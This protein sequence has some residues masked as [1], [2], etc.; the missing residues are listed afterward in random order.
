ME[1]RPLRPDAEILNAE[2]QP[3]R[4]WRGAAIA[5]ALSIFF[6]LATAYTSAATLLSRVQSTDVMKAASNG[7]WSGQI[8]WQMAYF[9]VAQLLLHLA[10]GAIALLVARA[11]VSLSPALRPKF[12]RL[13]V[14]WFA[15]LAFATVA[16]NALWYPRT[17]MGAHYH[18]LVSRA[19]GPLHLGQIVYGGIVAIALAVVAAAALRGYARFPARRRRPIAV[20]MASV[21]ALAAGATIFAQV[22]QALAAQQSP[23]MPHVIVLGIDSLRLD[24]VA[25]YG[26]TDGLTPNLDRFLAEADL[27][28]DTTTPAARTFSSWVAILT[29][30]SPPR[31]GAR[32]NLAPRDIVAANPTLADVLRSRGYRTVYSTDEVRF[33]NIDESFGFDQLITPPIGASDFLIGTY[34]ELPLASVV[35]NTRLG[36][37]LFPFSYGNRGVATM[38]QP[39]TYLGR[40]QRELEFDRPTLFVAHLTASHWPYHT[41]ETP[42]GVNVKEHP[43]DRPM[44]RIGL[45]TA[46]AMFGQLVG[47]LKQK[48]A[49]ENALVVVL[50]DHGEALALPN[51]T[52]FETGS[53]VRGLA[54][55]L[56]TMDLGHGQSVLS[57]SQY[58]V[59]LGFRSFGASLKFAASGRDLPR[60]TTVEDISPTILDLVGVGGQQLE[61]SGRSFA[62]ELLGLAATVPDD[63]IRYTETDLA[64]LPAPDGSIDEAET[65][66]ANSKF[67]TIDPATGRLH[68]RHSFRPLALAYKERAAYTQTNLLAAMP[69]GPYAHQFVYF[70]LATGQGELLLERPTDAIAARLWD[71]IH[72]HYGA[73]I[74]PATRVTREDWPRIGNEWDTF[75]TDPRGP[76]RGAT[77]PAG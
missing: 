41:S 18:D 54:A 34:N 61:P 4:P 1:C 19:V 29:G 70:D 23:A 5:A 59:L 35:V 72:D 43:D 20:A 25:R 3:L 63:R 13:I 8:A 16:Y 6:L 21:L 39:R 51:D 77:K 46:D 2:S 26:G 47:M 37:V 36:Q 75:F 17:L 33:A 40:L 10:F 55:P 49:F 31:T 65:A 44:Y 24:Q 12:G 28:K 56:K 53:I 60:P 58:H 64:V 42:F 66:R 30:R 50:S 67:F 48:G 71:A 74:K 7:V 73:E 27:L 11:T 32:F 15:L 76:G 68:I 69:A 14:G 62:P 38:F 22:R 45:K 9:G 52:F 57:P